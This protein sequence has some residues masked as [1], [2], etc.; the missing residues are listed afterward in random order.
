LEQE[1]QLVE[2]QLNAKR[3]L[4]I[5]ENPKV[6]LDADKDIKRLN[7]RLDVI[8]AELNTLTKAQK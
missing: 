6:D 3:A 8:Y 7:D 2:G 1:R 4:L 5:R